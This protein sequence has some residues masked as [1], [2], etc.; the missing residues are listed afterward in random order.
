MVSN[1]SEIKD[2]KDKFQNIFNSFQIL[3]DSEISSLEPPRIKI[4]SVQ[5]DSDLK[6]ITS[7]KLNLQSMYSQEIFS[8]LNNLDNKIENLNRKIKTIY[9]FKSSSNLFLEA[10]FSR[11][12][13]A[14]YS[15]LSLFKAVK[16]ICLSE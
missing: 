13:T 11:F 4:I 7:N 6:N 14:A 3:T 8:T 15:L 2:F 5:S 1:E 9:W 16:Y 10:F 12:W